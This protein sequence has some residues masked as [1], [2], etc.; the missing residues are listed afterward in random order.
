MT[1]LLATPVF[2]L[3]QDCG[4]PCI[5]DSD[6]STTECSWC[7]A[8]S[9][10][11]QR[12]C[13]GP[14]DADNCGSLPASNATG[15]LQWASWGDSVSKG[16]Y[17]SLK[18]LLTGYEAFHPA[19]NFGGAC[20]NVIKGKFCKDLWLNGVNGTAVYRRWDLITFNFGLHDLA[21]DNEYVNVTIYKR[22]LKNIAM[23]LQ[24]RSS[25]VF[26]VS[27]TP[28]PNVTLSPARDQ[29]DVPKYNVAAKEVMGDLNIPIIDVYSFVIEQCGG[30][31]HYTTCP[32]FQKDNN[33]HF[34][35][36]GYAAMAQF[37]HDAVVDHRSVTV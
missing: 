37:I 23:A 32:N 27:T 26:W 21:Q 20:G 15:L 25:H 12:V 28:V 9:P 19:N 24:L 14:P 13:G 30:D 18:N 29:D 35:S 36:Q 34:T 31:P 17:G 33:V 6:C 2:V 1:V 10:K 5:D 3:G 7:S 4:A 11:A 16:T 8:P 22:N